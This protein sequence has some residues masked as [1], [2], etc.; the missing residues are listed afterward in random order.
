[1]RKFVLALV[2]LAIAV[3]GPAAYAQ[4]TVSHPSIRYEEWHYSDVGM[5]NLSYH[6]I[7]YCDGS[8]YWQGYPDIHTYYANGDCA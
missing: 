4:F 6:F 2:G 1:M 8:V 3:S 7:E 5:Q